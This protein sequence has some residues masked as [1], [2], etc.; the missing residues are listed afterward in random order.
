MAV[1]FLDLARIHKPVKDELL[2]VVEDC[3]THNDFILGSRLKTFEGNFAQFVKSKHAIG[4]SSGTDALLLTLHALGVGP[5]D[6]V[7]CPA[8]G[9]VATADVIVRLGATV[10]FV[11]VR[12]DANIDPDAVRLAITEKTKAIIAVHLFGLISNI[13]VLA[14]IAADYG[15]YLIEDVA[16]ACGAESNG[17]AAGTFGIAGCF[18]FYPTKN[19]GGLGD[20]GMVI[21]ETDELAARLR[22]LRDHGRDGD[23][24]FTCVG[25]NSRLDSIQAAMLDIKLGTLAEDNADR[26]ANA[27]FYNGKLNKEVFTLPEYRDDGSHVYNLY[28]IRHANRNELKTFLSERGIE[29]RVYYPLAMHMQPCF[30]MLGYREGHFPVSEALAKSVLSLPIFPGLTR[31]ELD[32]VTH[33]L[34]LYA[35][36]HPMAPA[37]S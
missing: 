18:S 17:R 23:V 28:T 11:D 10:V 8:Y 37:A 33:T 31:K 25:Y 12:E 36:T 4:V 32:E 13:E 30:E 15:V 21:T 9:F 27:A 24:Q 35:K 6:E 34:D 7:I 3:I 1:S 26:M 19:L 14:Q 5:G 2:K 29:T 22:L 20:G 16:Q